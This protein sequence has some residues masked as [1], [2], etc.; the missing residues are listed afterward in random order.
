MPYSNPHCRL[1][2][3]VPGPVNFKLRNVNYVINRLAA[4]FVVVTLI[5][6]NCSH[7][8]FVQNMLRCTSY[9]GITW[10][11]QKLFV[12]L[13]CLW[14]IERHFKYTSCCCVCTCQR[15]KRPS[16]HICGSIIYVSR[17]HRETAQ[18][19]EGNSFICQTQTTQQSRDGTP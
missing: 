16:Y 2:L 3:T 10:I 1:L 12:M 13:E 15:M 9:Q 17:S 18:P 4:S 6:D 7:S 11:S 8:V 19:V 5:K 14:F